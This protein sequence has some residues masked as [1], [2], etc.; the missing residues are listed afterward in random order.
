LSP[1]SKRCIRDTHSNLIFFH[2]P[3]L[4][5]LSQLAATYLLLA[6]QSVPISSALLCHTQKQRQIAE[7]SMGEADPT[8][9]SLFFRDFPL[10]WKTNTGVR[11]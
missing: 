4:F 6:Q 3:L 5:D 1:N 9:L 8:G 7:K 10:A 11:H 2:L